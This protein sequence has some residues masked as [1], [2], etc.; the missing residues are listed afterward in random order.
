V[1][2]ED[3]EAVRY[4]SGSDHSHLRSELAGVDPTEHAYA[5]IWLS[6]FQEEPSRV[7]PALQELAL[8]TR[9]GDDVIDYLHGVAKREKLSAATRAAG[10]GAGVLA[11]L[12][13]CVEIKPSIFGVEIDVKAILKD[14]GTRLR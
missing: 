12:A 13:S 9:R 3:Q 5:I 11:Q 2:G 4:G 8:R 1:A 7:R 14:L 10:R 6:D